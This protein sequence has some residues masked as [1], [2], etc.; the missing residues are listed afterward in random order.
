MG[1]D[2]PAARHLDETYVSLFWQ[3][4][5]QIETEPLNAWRNGIAIIVD[6]KRAGLQNIGI[7]FFVLFLFCCLFC[8]FVLLFCFVCFVCFVFCFVFVFVF[9]FVLFVLFLFL[10]NKQR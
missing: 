10:L 1:L 8:C 5:Y 4:Y 2:K 9:V 6:L 7:F 3:T